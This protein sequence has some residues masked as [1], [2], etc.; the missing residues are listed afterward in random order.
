MFAYTPQRRRRLGEILSTLAETGP[1]NVWKSFTVDLPFILSGKYLRAI[2]VG[3][4]RC[5]RKNNLSPQEK[6]SN[7]LFIASSARAPQIQ[8]LAIEQAKRAVA[9]IRD[10]RVRDSNLKIIESFAEAFF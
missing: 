8:A 3:V 1:G 6:V 7:Y 5:F 4:E 2:S 10:R 9:K